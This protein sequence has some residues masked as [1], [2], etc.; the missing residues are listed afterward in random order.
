LY[1]TAEVAYFSPAPEEEHE[2]QHQEEA[3]PLELDAV[4]PALKEVGVRVNLTNS[5]GTGPSS[6]VV[7]I[8]VR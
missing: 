5:E 3:A 7:T 6:D 8:V 4:A 1:H 2:P